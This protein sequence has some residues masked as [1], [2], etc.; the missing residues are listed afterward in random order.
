MAVKWEATEE[1]SSI[2]FDER[3]IE[4]L[5]GTRMLSCDKGWKALDPQ[6]VESGEF[7]RTLDEV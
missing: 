1:E 3:T 7:L 5:K 2:K 4:R 6:R